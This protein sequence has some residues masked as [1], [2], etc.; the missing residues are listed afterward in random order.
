MLELTR[1]Q[2]E[3]TALDEFEKRGGRT[4]RG[5]IESRIVNKGCDWQVL[6][7]LLPRAPGAHFGVLIDGVS[8]KVKTYFPGS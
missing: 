6:V 5:R 4:D 8:G 1:D 3:Q 2:L 7:V